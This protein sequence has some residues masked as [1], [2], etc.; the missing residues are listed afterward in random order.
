MAK[1]M[2][3]SKPKLAARGERLMA[4]IRARKSAKKSKGKRSG[5]GGGS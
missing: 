3:F 4:E 1:R 2:T 5:R